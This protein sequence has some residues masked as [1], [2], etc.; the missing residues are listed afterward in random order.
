MF[1]VDDLKE[2]VNNPKFSSRFK[3]GFTSKRFTLYPFIFN[4]ILQPETKG[5]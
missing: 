5:L 1:E 3:G 4:H 2:L